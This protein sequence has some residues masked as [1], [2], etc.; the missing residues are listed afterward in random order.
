MHE[1]NEWEKDIW[2]RWNLALKKVDELHPWIG[3][4]H[5]E[6]T[7][8]NWKIVANLNIYKPI[9][10]IKLDLFLRKH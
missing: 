9:Y 5:Q 1:S 10:K 7:T 3:C 4:V 2:K 8:K 6:I